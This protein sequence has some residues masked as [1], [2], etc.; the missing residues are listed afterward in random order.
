MWQG[1]Q[2]ITDYTWKHILELP[3][4][5]CLPDVLN[6]FYARLE[7][8]N[9]ETCKRASAVPDD[10]VITL[11]AAD[12]SKTFKQV[13]IQTDYQDMYSKHA[14]TNWQVLTKHTLTKCLH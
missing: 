7:E 1:L 13:N 8:S 10:C 9:T 6:D 11:S 14:L 4:D 3:S 5:T 12:V 2:T